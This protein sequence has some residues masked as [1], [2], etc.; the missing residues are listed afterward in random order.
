[1]EN[2]NAALKVHAY[3]EFERVSSLTQDDNSELQEQMSDGMIILMED[4]DVLTSH[5]EASKENVDQ[6]ISDKETDIVRTLQEDWKTTETR[7]LDQQQMRNRN[8]VEEVIFTCENYREDISN[9]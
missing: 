8:I 4:R 5:L 6:K 1:M 9:H 7:I 2:F 3:Q